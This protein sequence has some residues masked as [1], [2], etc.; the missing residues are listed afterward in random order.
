MYNKTP[1][2]NLRFTRMISSLLLVKIMGWSK[3]SKFMISWSN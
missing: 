1:S 3:W 2:V